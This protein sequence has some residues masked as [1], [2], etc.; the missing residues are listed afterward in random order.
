MYRTSLSFDFFVYRLAFLYDLGPAARGSASLV[1]P[2]ICCVLVHLDVLITDGCRVSFWT[3]EGEGD[4]MEGFVDSL[5]VKVLGIYKV[6][7]HSM[8]YHVFFMVMEKL[9]KGLQ[10]ELEFDL[11][12]SNNKGAHWADKRKG[13]DRD[14]RQVCWM[15]CV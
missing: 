12:G 3:L 11:K 14:L 8:Q 5:L 6:R 7:L 1:L 10:P 15:C 13:R 4:R 2:A 9:G